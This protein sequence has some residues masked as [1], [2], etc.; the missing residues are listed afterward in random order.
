MISHTFSVILLDRKIFGSGPQA[1]ADT[2]QLQLAAMAIGR[3]LIV[4]EMP[5][6]LQSED[7]GRSQPLCN[8]FPA[9]FWK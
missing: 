3:T 6:L 1:Y 9:L 2:P 5:L 8:G 7:E 4:R